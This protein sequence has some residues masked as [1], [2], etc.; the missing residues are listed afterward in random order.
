MFL[1]DGTPQADGR[2]GLTGGARGAVGAHHLL[3]LRDHSTAGA[4]G[5][6]TGLA[7]GGG[8]RG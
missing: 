5:A 3:S 4:P 2:S 6:R 8:A 1:G 7:V